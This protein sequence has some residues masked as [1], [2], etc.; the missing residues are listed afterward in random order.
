MCISMAEKIIIAL[1]DEDLKERLV[2]KGKKRVLDFDRKTTAM[3]TLKLYQSI[4]TG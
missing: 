1:Q 2:A 3:E 4:T